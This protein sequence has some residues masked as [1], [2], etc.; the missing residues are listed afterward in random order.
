MI[1]QKNMS[2]IIVWSRSFPFVASYLLFSPA[3]LEPGKRYPLIL[4]LHGASQRS[5]EAYL[6]AS[7]K[8][9]QAQP[10]FVL[11]PMASAYTGWANRDGSV[12]ALGFAI[13]VLDEVM[14]RAPVDQARIYVTGHS[15]GGTG[16]FAALAYFPDR[17]A[18]G[19][20]VNGTWFEEQAA[21]LRDARLWAFHGETDPLFPIE[22]TRAFIEAVKVAGGKPKFTMM[23][24]IGHQSP[25]A[26]DR[27]ELWAWLFAQRIE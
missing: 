17:F 21:R 19:V 16:T 3:P 8:R 7:N 4:S 14:A 27:A 18:A 13:D 6:L 5:Y 23:K 9:Q 26:Y 24:G 12:G 22:R 10:S 15:M 11:L 2:G 20:A 1:A 25:P